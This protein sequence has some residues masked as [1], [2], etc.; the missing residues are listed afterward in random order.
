LKKHQGKVQLFKSFG[1]LLKFVFSSALLYPLSSVLL[2]YSHHRRII[3]K[4]KER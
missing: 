2:Y 1:I 4:F 3:K